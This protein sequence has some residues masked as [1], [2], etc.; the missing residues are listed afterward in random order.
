MTD[1]PKM[2]RPVEDKAL[3]AE[4]VKP[5][6]DWQATSADGKEAMQGSWRIR[7]QQ[8]GGSGLWR[9]FVEWVGE[10]FQNAATAERMLERVLR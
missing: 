3:K 8:L 5:R 9:P 10:D 6:F 4:P 1:K 7:V 2:Q